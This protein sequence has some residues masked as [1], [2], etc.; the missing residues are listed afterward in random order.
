MRVSQG[1]E[2][3]QLTTIRIGGPLRQ[4][5]Q[6]DS[7]QELSELVRKF[8]K[9]NEPFVLIGCGSNIV[10]PE[11]A[12]QLSVL[13]FTGCAIAECG[14]DCIELES[15]CTISRLMGWCHGHGRGGLEF[16]IGIPGS[17]GGALAVNAGA[18]GESVG[19]RL[20]S[21]QVIDDQGRLQSW[22]TRDFA[23]SYRDCRIKFGQ[24]IIVSAILT[25]PADCRENIGRRMREH[26]AHRLANH[27]VKSPSAGCFFKNPR[28]GKDGISAGRLIDQCG[29]KGFCRG[30][31]QIS[32]EHANFIVNN[33]RADLGQLNEFSR[34]IQEQV[35]RKTAFTLEREVIWIAPDGRKY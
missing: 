3:R 22:S 1:I 28:P 9:E 20:I 19:D 34:F 12:E 15:G 18:F 8:R 27:P 25:A 6:T 35:Q 23:F 30:D 32:S 4:L 31:L 5:I 29:L 16:L 21:A 33:G 10:F 26:I 7:V 24:E 2:G 17:L 14:P 13:R 11:R